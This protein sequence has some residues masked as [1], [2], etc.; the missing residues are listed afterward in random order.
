M[1]ENGVEAF[2]ILNVNLD[3]FSI[4]KSFKR[5]LG[6]H[7]DFE[8]YFP[9]DTLECISSVMD[10]GTHIFFNLALWVVDLCAILNKF[11]F[12]WIHFS[13]HEHSN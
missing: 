11:S 13:R 9:L 1:E 3:L 7:I 2:G 6:I 8:I 12:F 10:L 5:D 4:F